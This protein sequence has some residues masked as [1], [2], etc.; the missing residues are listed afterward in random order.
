MFGW[1]PEP[2]GIRSCQED[3]GEV[4]TEEELWD[5]LTWLLERIVP[6]AE[7]AGGAELGRDLVGVNHVPIRDGDERRL[8]GR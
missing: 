7:R 6:V 3:D 4:Q 8:H 5:N 1:L 2:I